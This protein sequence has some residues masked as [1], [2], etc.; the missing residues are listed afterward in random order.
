MDKDNKTPAIITR[1]DI[2]IAVAAGICLLMA[3]VIPEFQV[4]TACIA[5]LLCIQDGVKASWK[6]GVLRLIVTGVGGL[7]AVLVILLDNAA[8]N[9]WLFVVMIM[10]GL[11][12]TLFGCKLAKVPPFNARIG[13]ITFILVV[14]TKTGADRVTYAIFRLLSTLYGVAAVIIV[15]AVFAMFTR[16]KV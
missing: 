7:I 16:K 14:L 6:A 9:S 4:M 13:G 12:L 11:L 1:I 8:G 3:K 15:A 10:L 5:T 2:Q